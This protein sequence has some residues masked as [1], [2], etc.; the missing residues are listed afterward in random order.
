MNKIIEYLSRAHWIRVKI[1][2]LELMLAEY[3]A[4]ASSTPS[5]SFD[6][7]IIDKSRDFDAPFI[8][9]VYKAIETEDKINSL[10]EQLAKVEEETMDF[11]EKLPNLDYRLILVYRYLNWLSWDKI[12]DK[13][14]YSS[15]T[16]RRWHTLAIDELEKLSNNE[17]V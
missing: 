10:K 12:A 3:N 14:Y 5:Q 13:M 17:Q 11:I 16:I 15:A 7:E 4:R 9:W 2:K 8:K 1:S 6:K